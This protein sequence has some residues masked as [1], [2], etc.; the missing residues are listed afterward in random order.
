MEYLPLLIILG[1]IGFALLRLIDKSKKTSIPRVK[2]S[3]ATAKRVELSFDEAIPEGFQ[4]YTE[5]PDIAGLSYKKAGAI[6]FANGVKQE[7]RFEREPENKHDANAIK[8]IGVFGSNSECIGYVPKELSEQIIGSGLFE[9]VKPRLRRIFVGSSDYIDINYQILGP[10]ADKPTFDDYLYKK[11][12]EPD[13]IEYFKFFGLNPSKE[14]NR[15]DAEALINQHQKSCSP[16]QIKEWD[17]YCQ[18]LE[19]FNDPDF[20]EMYDLKKV[21]RGVLLKAIDQLRESG[22][23]YCDISDD[24]DQVVEKVLEIKPDLEKTS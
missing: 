2:A 20:R 23:T 3:K 18:I 14:T 10:K 1:L 17:C 21:S 11:P 15:G 8:V 4:I 7:L 5:R 9:L 19:E 22:S 16:E 6:R 12:A 13:Q 24:I